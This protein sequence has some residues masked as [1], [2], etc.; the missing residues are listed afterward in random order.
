[1][2]NEDRF[3]CSLICLCGIYS[4]SRNVADAMLV[5][6]ANIQIARTVD[7]SENLQAPKQPLVLEETQV[8]LVTGDDC[9]VL[10]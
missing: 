10:G 9:E 1:M 7:I 5:L 3:V 8:Y 6:S 4:L 2:R